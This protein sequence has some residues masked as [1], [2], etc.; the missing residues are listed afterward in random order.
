MTC[1]VFAASRVNYEDCRLSREEFK[2]L[3]DSKPNQTSWH[4]NRHAISS[5]R[6]YRAILKSLKAPIFITFKSFS[7]LP[8]IW[9]F[10][11][12]SATLRKV[13]FSSYIF[14]IFLSYIRDLKIANRTAT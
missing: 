1:L 9:N 13:F 11:K 4:A 8:C 14:Y 7:S 6:K 10:L 5:Y 12:S 2:K 3:K